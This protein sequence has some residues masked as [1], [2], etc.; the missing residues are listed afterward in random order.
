[1]AEVSLYMDTGVL[2]PRGAGDI[3]RGVMLATY[4]PLVPRLSTAIPLH[5]VNA[6]I[7]C[8]GKGRPTTNREV[9][10][11]EQ[12]Y[13][14]TLSLISALDRG[15]CS[16]PRPGRFTPWK[17]SRYPFYRRLVGPQVRFDRM[18]KISLPPGFDPQTAQLVESRCTDRTIASNFMACRVTLFMF[19]LHYI[20]G[21]GSLVGIATAYGL[22]GLG[23]ESRW[24]EIFRTSPDRP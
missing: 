16:A 21:P 17:E 4:V 13:T 20:C 1:M 19:L 14:S 5:S 8:K 7:T 24:G 22:D 9:P 23:I 15:G 18:R 3:G 10:E 12:R 6:F 2:S 11:G